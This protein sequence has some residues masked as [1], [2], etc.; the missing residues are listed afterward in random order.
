[1]QNVAIFHKYLKKAS[2]NPSFSVM[3]AREAGKYVGTIRPRADAINRRRA[4]KFFDSADWVMNQS[5][6]HDSSSSSSEAMSYEVCSSQILESLNRNTE[7]NS[8]LD[9]L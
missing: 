8:L 2:K 5:R 6:C 7:E 1:M 3:N 9:D 4:I